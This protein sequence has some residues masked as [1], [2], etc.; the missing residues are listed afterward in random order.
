[1]YLLAR[2]IYR[3]SSA[4]LIVRGTALV[5]S[6]EHALVISFIN[7]R[8]L[9]ILGKDYRYLSHTEHIT[10]D[11]RSS[12]QT[13]KTSSRESFR[14]MEFS[15]EEPFSQEQEKRFVNIVQK[16]HRPDQFLIIRKPAE[17]RAFF[18]QYTYDGK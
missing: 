14:T 7:R 6:F 9:E 8:A 13:Q 1:M 10:A 4:C 16:R 18:L 12:C 15:Y 5:P 2:R 3:M 17:R 11:G